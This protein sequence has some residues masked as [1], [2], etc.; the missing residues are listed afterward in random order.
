MRDRVGMV[1]TSSLSSFVVIASLAGLFAARGVSGERSLRVS[2]TVHFEGKGK[3]YLDLVTQSAFHSSSLVTPYLAIDVGPDDDARGWVPFVFEGVAS[4][5]YAIRSFQ[6]ENGNGV[7]DTRLLGPPREP[8]G[9]YRPS[10]PLMR[11]PRFEEC[12]FELTAD[13]S[14]IQITVR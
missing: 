2:G 6:D 8:W 5:T 3:V 11:G 4:G 1:T 7:L 10:R 14:D 13:R 12:A 9:M